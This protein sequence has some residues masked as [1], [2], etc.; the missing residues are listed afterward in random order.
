MEVQHIIVGNLVTLLALAVIGATGWLFEPYLGYLFWGQLFALALRGPRDRIKK[1]NEGIDGAARRLMGRL[2]LGLIFISILSLIGLG[3]DLAYT[4]SIIKSAAQQSPNAPHWL[5]KRIEPLVD[6]LKPKVI[7]AAAPFVLGL[8]DDDA[9]ECCELI[10]DTIIEKAGLYGSDYESL[11]RQAINAANAMIK[12]G[13]ADNLDDLKNEIKQKFQLL[14]GKVQNDEHLKDQGK[15]AA[16]Q[17][18]G[19]LIKIITSI[20]HFF[21]TLAAFLAASIGKVIGAIIFSIAVYAQLAREND[22]I[23]LLILQVAPAADDE[24]RILSQVTEAL[25]VSPI[26]RA[27]SFG[28][29]SFTLILL[30]G[31]RCATTSAL[32]AMASGLFYPFFPSLLS[33]LPWALGLALSGAYL[34]AIIFFLL[35]T[36]ILSKIAKT[37]ESA[38]ATNLALPLNF[39]RL[40]FILGFQ[41]LGIQGVILGPLLLA[42]ATLSFRVLARTSGDVLPDDDNNNNDDQQGDTSKIE[43]TAATI[44]EENRSSAEHTPKVFTTTIADE[45]LPVDTPNVASNSKPTE[46]V[47]KMVDQK[48]PPPSTMPSSSKQPVPPVESKNDNLVPNKKPPVA[49]KP[50]IQVP[51]PLNLPVS[52]N[53]NKTKTTKRSYS[54]AF[55]KSKEKKKQ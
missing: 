35:H 47:Q 12:R 26:F 24:V 5:K 55:F 30:F 46:I 36:I 21:T 39:V 54:P 15:A 28:I 16:Q 49:P 48:K 14:K 23:S 44:Q 4:G 20:I 32:L 50:E 45:S 42:V 29:A 37:Y 7:E 19:M 18:L 40:A 38:F 2:C 33:S 34:R 3:H 11:G 1:K 8:D 43:E 6:D 17:A 27:V 52:T 51:P 41:R 10:E 25:V 9:I 53:G 31:A 13:E 22:Y